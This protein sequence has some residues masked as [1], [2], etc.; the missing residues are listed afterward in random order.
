MERVCRLIDLTLRTRVTAKADMSII[1]EINRRI[2][3]KKNKNK[4]TTQTHTHVH[5]QKK[6][7]KKNQNWL[8]SDKL[9]DISLFVFL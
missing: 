7:I 5:T 2:Q 4:N 3:K 8:V 1:S 6:K 9:Y